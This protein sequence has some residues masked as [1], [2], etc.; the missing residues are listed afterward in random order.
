MSLHVENAN[1][2]RQWLNH[3]RALSDQCGTGIAT[4]DQQ[5]GT[6]S[7]E[8]SYLIS[9][10]YSAGRDDES[11]DSSGLGNAALGRLRNLSGYHGQAQSSVS[12]VDHYEGQLR[13]ALNTAWSLAGQLGVPDFKAWFVQNPIG[14]ASYDE[15]NMANKISEARYALQRAEGAIGQAQ[16]NASE[17]AGDQE[18]QNVSYAGSRLYEN[19]DDAQDHFGE[20]TSAAGWARSHQGSVNTYIDRALSALTDLERENATPVTG[21]PSP[22]NAP[23]TLFSPQPQP[24]PVS[25]GFF[26]KPWSTQ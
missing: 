16:G 7:S 25:T 13:Q 17:V 20:V 24:V 15:G 3:A 26:S 22:S 9:D 5:A 8:C 4:L 12:T 1:L 23:A 18:G 6:A 21:A 2:T 14:S 10:V 19:S 11:T